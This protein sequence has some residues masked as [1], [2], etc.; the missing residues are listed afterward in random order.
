MQCAQPS[1]VRARALQRPNREAARGGVQVLRRGT[2]KRHQQELE[3]AFPVSGRW[4]Q[5][6]RSGRVLAAVPQVDLVGFRQALQ[7]LNSSTWTKRLRRELDRRAIG[8]P[9]IAA[10]ARAA[11][12]RDTPVPSSPISR[13]TDA[14][15]SRTPPFLLGECGSSQPLT[16]RTCSPCHLPPWPCLV[17]QPCHAGIPRDCSF[18]FAV[19]SRTAA[20]GGRLH[21][22][23]LAVFQQRR[24]RDLPAMIQSRPFGAR[25]VRATATPRKGDQ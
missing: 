4:P 14:L 9:V 1:L 18:V 25:T 23:V 15:A 20:G 3:P 5:N 19:R 17:V 22:T 8:R 11:R 13:Y 7:C 6:H 21:A 24:F 10:P 2:A 12:P 16:S